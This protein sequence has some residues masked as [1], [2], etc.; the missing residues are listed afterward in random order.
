MIQAKRCGL[1]G[2]TS[3]SKRLTCSLVAFDRLGILADS[4]KRGFCLAGQV[5]SKFIGELCVGFDSIQELLVIRVTI[6]LEEVIQLVSQE[7]GQQHR[8][9][10]NQDA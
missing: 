3:S 8:H 7:R 1:R 10:A 5:V 4:H 6:T 2:H 9:D